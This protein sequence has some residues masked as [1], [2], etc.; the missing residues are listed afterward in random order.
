MNARIQTGTIRAI[1]SLALV[2]SAPVLVAA[3][4]ADSIE[5][6]F[7]RALFAEE[8]HRD[9]EAA[10]RD[11]QAVVRSMDEQRRL[12]ATALFRLGE[13]YRKLNRT[14]DAVAQFQRVVVEF[15]AEE[16][17]VRISR[18]N[19]A[20]LGWVPPEPAATVV[21]ASAAST[22]MPAA[23]PGPPGL[24]TADSTVTRLDHDLALLEAQLD[25]VAS[26]KDSR[27][28]RNM[29][30]T[31]FP[32]ESRGIV[33]LE[34]RIAELEIQATRFEGSL[35]PDH[36]D[37]VA[38]SLQFEL[39]ARKLRQESED[40][41]AG[42]IARRDAL[43]TT[44][45]HIR[46]TLPTTAQAQASG[47]PAS[48]GGGVGEGQPS[49]L[50]S[51]ATN[52]EEDQIRQ[53]Q[54]MV[55]NSP[56][57]INPSTQGKAWPLYAAAQKG[58]LAVAR[59]LLDHGAKTSLGTQTT[60]LHAAAQAGHKAMVELLLARGA[61]VDARTVRGETPLHLAAR[62]GFVAISEVLLAHKADPNAAAPRGQNEGG[63]SRLWMNGA[64]LN[65]AVGLN[66]L[67]LMQLLLDKGADPNNR[68]DGEG[69]TKDSGY[70]PLR[71]AT[72]PE[73]VRLL[74][75]RGADPNLP[76]SNG[77]TLLHQAAASGDLAIVE[78]L[79]QAGATPDG[80]DAGATPTGTPLIEAIRARKLAVAE[81]LL[82]QGASINRMGAGMAPLHVAL[83]QADFDATT[84]L[85]EHGANPNLAR[86]NGV[87][88]IEQALYLDDRNPSPASITLMPGEA[89][90]G[91]VASLP[92]SDP[93]PP[94][95][96]GKWLSLLL[97]HGAGVNPRFSDAW[98]LIHHL[99]HRTMGAVAWKEFLLKKPEVNARGPRE[100]TALMVA[101]CRGTGDSLEALLTAGADV[102]AR[103]E[104]GNTALHFA[105]HLRSDNLRQL[106]DA[107]ANPAVTNRFGT[108][109]A[110]LVREPWSNW[111][112]D[113]MGVLIPQPGGGI[114]VV[115]RRRD[116]ARNQRNEELLQILGATAGE[117]SP[118]R[119]PPPGTTP[120]GEGASK[121]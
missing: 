61:P 41:L 15:P 82:E 10:A 69:Q 54:A 33:D 105:A 23:K 34:S 17:L 13:C 49:S 35:T 83:D 12:A 86:E 88:P 79:L 90:S 73:A 109:P 99:A 84:W 24:G 56:D 87:L 114:P 19:L 118:L 71:F 40:V 45:K 113:R 64:P 32:A 98:H 27:R 74:L 57:L 4:P 20:G 121:L 85:L 91:P 106:V 31:F 65:A 50:G 2:L 53:I 103:D 93:P 119:P 77:T 14:N 60:P 108:T 16:T 25:A 80:P 72:S 46:S 47:L 58:H 75:A 107:G 96:P 100:V 94:V 22:P 112:A 81:R 36:P 38:I 8:G 117:P 110:D 42:Q 18:Q 37:R 9:F 68:D 5:D 55:A 52:E 78:I 63:F 3:E 44:L 7:K 21:A 97:D 76:G 116:P 62:A 26:M 11:Y 95:I 59:Y 67:D 92:V 29:L 102:N 28:S 66:R 6:I 115:G 30:K 120:A 43:R 70:P 101:V 48:T 39:I 89:V 104:L 51:P 1:L 111:R